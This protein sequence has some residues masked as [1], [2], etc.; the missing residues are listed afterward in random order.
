MLLHSILLKS[1]K[2]HLTAHLS[3]KFLRTLQSLYLN[4]SNQIAQDTSSY[5]HHEETN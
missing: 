2:G 5:Q 3:L 1:L 4:A